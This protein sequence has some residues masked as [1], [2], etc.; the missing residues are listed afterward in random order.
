MLA[1]CKSLR[2][3]CHQRLGSHSRHLVIA[4]VFT[5]AVSRIAIGIVFAAVGFAAIGG[6]TV[7]VR[8]EVGFRGLQRSDWRSC[9]LN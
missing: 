9:H 2:D 5:L 3:S 1:Y 7:T 6:T 8:A 4:A